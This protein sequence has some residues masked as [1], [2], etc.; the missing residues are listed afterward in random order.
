MIAVTVT[1]TSLMRISVIDL[2]TFSAILLIAEVR[3]GQLVSLHEER[4]TIDL[5]YDR[6]RVIS[7]AG[8]AR[9][10]RTIRRFDRI[11][12]KFSPDR[13]LI[14]ATAAMRQAGNR[15]T[16]S[17]ELREV[18]SLTV[19]I[20]EEKQEAQFGAR[21]ALIGLKHPPAN[22]V[23]V[24]IG[25]G[26]TEFSRPGTN[27]FASLPVGAVWASGAW[28]ENRPKDRTQRDLFYFARAEQAMLEIDTRSFK[29]C[30]GVV[31]IGGTIATLAAV[32]LK[33]KTFDADRVHGHVLKTDAIA[34][35][36]AQLSV[37]PEQAIRALVPFDPSRAR[38]LAAGTYLWGAVL[39]RLNADRVVVSARGLRW[40]VAAYLAGLP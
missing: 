35:T 20:L 39:N 17:R 19:R 12:S 10:V 33:L 38:V 3:N 22:L 8:I 13:G 36:A 24:D 25:G 1:A 5:A 40:G 6:G 37:M 21:G 16:V 18:T 28:K 30:D 31:G 26:S 2:G 9:A 27:T 15:Y 34:A 7:P 29:G 14:V 32:D 11:T 23:V 4:Q